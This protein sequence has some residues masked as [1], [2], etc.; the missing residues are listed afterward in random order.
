MLAKS[1]KK[2]GLIILI[3]ACLWNIAVKLINVISFDR[4]IDDI[5]SQIETIKKDDKQ[6]NNVIEKDD[7]TY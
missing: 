3:I 6:K 1:W 4:A 7:T 5:K 2:I